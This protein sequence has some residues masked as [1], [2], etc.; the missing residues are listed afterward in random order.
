MEP[1][2]KVI[3]RNFST[4]QLASHVGSFKIRPVLDESRK[5]Y[6]LLVLVPFACSSLWQLCLLEM[7]IQISCGGC[8]SMKNLLFPGVLGT[9]R[10]GSLTLTGLVAF[11]SIIVVCR[12][13]RNNFGKPSERF[14]EAGDW[15]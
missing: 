2:P 15:H 4:L 1:V 11:R 5:V 14:W 6:R 12:C 9:I 8:R 13:Q 7:T 3:L 10:M